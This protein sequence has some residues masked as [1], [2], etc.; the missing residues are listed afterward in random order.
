V[1]LSAGTFRFQEGEELLIPL[2]LRQEGPPLLPFLVAKP[3]QDSLLLLV[4]EGFGC[5]SDRALDGKPHATSRECGRKAGKE[6]GRSGLLPAGG[7]SAELRPFPEGKTLTH[8][9]FYL[10]GEGPAYR[11]MCEE[12]GPVERPHSERLRPVLICR[13]S[14]QVVARLL[15]WQL[16]RQ[17]RGELPRIRELVSLLELGEEG[18]LKFF[19]ALWDPLRRERAEKGEEPLAPELGALDLV[20]ELAPELGAL[21]LVLELAPE[22]GALDLVL[23][24]GE[25]AREVRREELSYHGPALPQGDLLYQ[26]AE[27]LCEAYREISNNE[28]LSG[29]RL[30]ERALRVYV[31]VQ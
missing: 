3:P 2:T 6:A 4:R 20:L 18:F 29:G 28:G 21:D 26:L 23:E 30:D 7:Q 10:G 8:G 12:T 27:L 11:V 9:V 19:S 13:G 14:C 16:P 5:L 22:L 25:I 1:P 17:L 15:P 24:L 31:F